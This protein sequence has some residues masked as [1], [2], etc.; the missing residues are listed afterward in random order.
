M[1]TACVLSIV[2]VVLLAAAIRFSYVGSVVVDNPWRADAGKYVTLALN[3]VAN[4]MYSL[5]KEAPFTPVN[6]ITPGYPVYLAFFFKSAETVRAFNSS[7]MTSQAVLGTLSVLLTLYLG[8]AAGGIGVGLTAALLLAI[9]PHHVAS[10]GYLLTETLFTF[11]L[12][13]TSWL[14]VANWKIHRCWIWLLIG[15]VAAA[16][17]LVR[18]VLLMFP[19]IIAIPLFIQRH[20]IGKVVSIVV[21]V[22][23]GIAMAN[24]PWQVWKNEHPSGPEPSLF[25]AAI[26]LGGY[27]DLIYKDPALKGFP[28]RDDP[29]NSRSQTTTGAL[30]VIAE[31]AIAEPTRYLKWYLFGKPSMFWQSENLGAVG[32]AFIYPVSDSIYNR[33]AWAA[34]SMEVMMVLHPWLALIAGVTSAWLLWRSLK[35]DSSVTANPAVLLSATF[36]GSFTA[37]HMVLGPLQRY[38][39]PVYPFAYVLAAFG[40]VKL[41]QAMRR[42]SVSQ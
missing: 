22:S 1:S 27:P 17:S 29:E 40:L 9:S 30:R 31:R 32:G 4:G 33:Q 16:G 18:P 8:R 14:A 36:M 28:Y 21:C 26:Q 7:V 10:N 34:W 15:V 6:Y 38:A 11:L 19:F 42:V 24:L 12:L 39:Y 35:G 3:M 13:V 25:A 41:V 2:G 23:L 37:V 20:S 5:E